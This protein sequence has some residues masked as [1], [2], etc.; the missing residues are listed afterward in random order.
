MQYMLRS[1]LTP[2]KL[3]TE[4][5]P[6]TPIFILCQDTPELK[7]VDDFVETLQALTHQGLEVLEHARQQQS[8]SVDR[9]RPR[10]KALPKGT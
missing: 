4:S 2:F 9:N 3:D 1:G 5:H 7:S 6:R 10:P 8:V